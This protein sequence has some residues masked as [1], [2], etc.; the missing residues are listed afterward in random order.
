MPAEPEPKDHIEAAI[1]NAYRWREQMMSEGLTLSQCASRAG[2]SESL[3]RKYLPLINLSPAILKGALAGHL[4]PSVTMQ[5]LL[6]AAR[7]LDWSKQ[8]QF[9]G[10]ERVDAIKSS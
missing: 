5:G 7:D 1:G 9:L 3:V 6:A 4:P 2:L 8:A 10:L